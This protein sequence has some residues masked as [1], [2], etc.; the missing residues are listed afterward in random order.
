MSSILLTRAGA[1]ALLLFAVVPVASAEDSYKPAVKVKRI[2]QTETTTS[3]D[4]I[5]YP[6]VTDPEVQTL[7]VEIPPGG[8]TGWHEHP[9][10]AYAYIM[11]GTIEVESETGAKKTFKAGDSFA[12]MVGHKHDGRVVGDET[13]R[14]LMIVTG[15]KGKPF[16]VRTDPPR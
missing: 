6:D 14:I 16:S 2:L 4:P 10:P 15:E 5:R 11:A 12:E 13:V 7:I 1:A 3:G 8:E 9:V